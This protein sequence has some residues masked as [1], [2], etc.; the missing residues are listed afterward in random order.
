MATNQTIKRIY[1]EKKSGFN[2]TSH[3]LYSDLKNYL[4]LYTLESVR[5]L[6]RY[7]VQG[8][9]DETYQQA[10][11]TVFSEPP[12]DR[13]FEE[14]FESEESDQIIAVEYLPGQYDQRADSAVQCIQMISHRENPIIKTAHVYI[15][16]GTLSKDELDGVKTFLINAVDSK[17]ASLEKPLTLIE[18]SPVPA[19]VPEIEGFGSKSN[20]EL[21]SLLAELGLAMSIEDL[22]FC[23]DHFKNQEDRNP[24]L[25]EIRMLD[26]YWSDHCR[27][28][29]FQTQIDNISFE[30]GIFSQPIQETLKTYMKQ[31]EAVHGNKDKARCLM[32][33]AT[34]AAKDMIKRGVVTDIEISD[35][36]NACSIVVEADIDGRKE[37]WLVMFK[38][39]THNHPTEIE[40]FGGAATCV[41]GCIRD[42]LSGRSYVYQAMRVTGCGDPRKSLNETLPGKLPQRKISTEA[43][44]GYSSY[45]NQIGL[46]TGLVREIY[47]PNYVAK[48]MEVGA[49]I[50]AAPKKNVI[51]EKPVPGDI[52]VL[53]G[54]RTGRDGCG[55]ATGSSKSHT[56]ESIVTSGAEVQKGNPP[57]ERK[58]QRLFRDSKVSRLIKKCNDFGAGGVSVAI[59]ELADGLLIDLDRVPKKYDGLDGTE[60]S[61]SESQE[62]M[63]VLL[64]KNDVTSFIQFA[65]QE[66][67][68]AVEVAVVTAEE[69]VQL[70]WRGKKIVDLSRAFIESNGVRQNINID[71]SAPPADQ[72]FFAVLDD[73]L[74]GETLENDWL[75]NL[76]QL[77]VCNQKGLIEHFDSTIGAGSVHLPFGGKYQGTPTEAMIAK[78]PILTGDTPTG[79]I[80]SHGFNP[81]LSSWSPFHGA[82]YAV[83]E[84]IAKI[85]AVGG[86]HR[87]ARLTLQEYFE[88]LGQNPKRWSKPF[89]ALL[90]AFHAQMEFGT[91]AIGGKDSMS[92]TFEEISVPPTLISFA[93]APTNVN[94]VISPEIK[95]VGSQMVLI[96]LI[97]NEAELPDF[98]KL[99]HQ[100]ELIS[101]LIQKDQILSAHTITTGGLAAAVSKMA[102]GNRI[103]IQIQSEFSQSDLFTP[104]YGS[105]ICEID[106]S[107][108]P[109][110][111]FH[112]IEF[113]PFGTT[114]ADQK[115]FING[116]EIGLDVI[117]SKLDTPLEMVFPT[118][119][120]HQAGSP[121]PQNYTQRNTQKPQTSIAQPRILIPVFPGTNCEYDTARAFERAGGK[122]NVFVINNLS[123]Q[124]I[125]ESLTIM[126]QK[127]DQSQIVMIPGGFSA[128][129]EPEGSGKFIAAVFRNHAIKEAIARLINQR[130]GLMLG[131][132]N[133]FQALVKLGLLPYGE[134]RDI[135]ETSPT[136][137]FNTIGRHVSTMVQTRIGSTLSPWLSQ[138]DVGDIHSI[139]VSHGEGR[140]VAPLDVLSSLESKG[141]IATQ[142]VDESGNPSLNV[143]HN[144]NGSMLGI[145]GIC[146]PDGRI[147]GKMGHTERV[148]TNVAKNIYGNKNQKLF[149]GGVA[150]FK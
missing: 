112:G 32:D 140:F 49:V 129:D 25:T 33:I 106:A 91:P 94:H 130:D 82:V 1:V 26:T 41:G 88:K 5:I 77:N 141:Q 17:E 30:D 117:Q 148:G 109:D 6:R 81:N 86:D 100:Y 95:Q 12:V 42:P 13:I 126:A 15:L 120:E 122:P 59:G 149:A 21:I 55:G 44:H 27:H 69:R 40:P 131:I 38:N 45:G 96:P 19:D 58:I 133:G 31:R 20:Q 116:I 68:E 34:L 46:A 105:I 60:L 35:E 128:G 56:G 57:T 102:L 124:K 127:I 80:M 87:Q 92:G 119:T 83:V 118:K 71:V 101:Q 28:T 144:P 63:A 134:I 110:T 37:D 99:N 74:T 24:T 150:Y 103:G 113:K 72:N 4:N 123:A 70:L 2:I 11:S 53:V 111:L 79:T 143:P 78:L 66:N 23:Q 61:I 50:A 22:A 64:D 16:K 85:V 142:Y 90:G 18:E 3:H 76:E 125:D 104:N 67:V 107:Q 75:A 146:S 97:R 138:H 8:I 136:L 114:T 47:H 73:C 9:S 89:S 62:R 43:A 48:H 14:S 147:F 121:Q 10:K 98:V 39:E 115:I 51:R 65:E 84:S 52:I 36:I 135:D 132:C 29:T 145:E 93:V 139:A 137:T 54:G 108:N 7:D